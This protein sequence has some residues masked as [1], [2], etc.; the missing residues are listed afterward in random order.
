MYLSEIM[1]TGT[2]APLNRHPVLFGVIGFLVTELITNYMS[3]A[4]IKIYSH[5]KITTE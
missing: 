2:Q 3:T 1:K 4:C 5:P